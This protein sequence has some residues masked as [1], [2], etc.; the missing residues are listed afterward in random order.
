MAAYDLNLDGV[1]EIVTGAG[2]GGAPH[3]RVFNSAN[4]AVIREFMAYALDFT[5]GVFVAAGDFNGNSIPDIVTGAGAGGGPH[6]KIFNYNTLEI[7]EETMAYDT[8]FSG[9]V[10]VALAD[11]NLDNLVDL[12][13][14]A[15]PGGGPHVK[16]FT[17]TG[18][19]DELFS[20]FSGDPTDTRGVF[21]GG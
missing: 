3:V 11:V 5:G 17:K 12:V 20:Y 7:V 10:R 2:P 1:N 14:A 9:G 19:L 18:S 16:T 8:V 13:T 15:G 4:M 21:V 6:V